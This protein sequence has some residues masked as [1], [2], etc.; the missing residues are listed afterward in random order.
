M[1][2]NLHCLSIGTTKLGH[3]ITDN[4]RYNTWLA[5][6]HPTSPA[7]SHVWMWPL[8]STGI[9]ELLS[10][11]EPPSQAPTLNP[12]SCG[13]VL[14]SQKNMLILEAKKVAKEEKQ[15]EKEFKKRAREEKKCIK[16]AERR[17]KKKQSKGK[18]IIK[19]F[20]FY[21]YTHHGQA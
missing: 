20:Q 2:V 12:K 16:E 21:L 10:Y 13:R 3:D 19:S 6:S 4:D 11:P 14:T 17:Q 5:Q 8:Q 7:A 9:C 15:R 1:I 18:L